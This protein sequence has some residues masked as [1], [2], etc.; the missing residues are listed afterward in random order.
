M[1]ELQLFCHALKKKEK[2]HWMEIGIRGA[3][4]GGISVILI[5]FIILRCD[6]YQLCAF[7]RDFSIQFL[8]QWIH[9]SGQEVRINKSQ[10]G[11]Q[12]KEKKWQVL[13]PHHPNQTSTPIPKI[14]HKK[15]SSAQY[16]MLPKTFRCIMD[17]WVQPLPIGK[18]SINGKKKRTHKRAQAPCALPPNNLLN[19]EKNEY[20]QTVGM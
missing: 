19:P 11:P 12:K 5:V 4:A 20:A 8:F 16:K 1:W 17:P 15:H 18:S 3:Q 6:F 13:T 14:F 10:W 2:E 9:L 7:E